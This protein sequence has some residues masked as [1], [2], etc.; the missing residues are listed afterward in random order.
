M[1]K[2]IYSGDNFTIV[3]NPK[4]FVSTPTPRPIRHFT[5]DVSYLTKVAAVSR[6]DQKLPYDT[7][8]G[9]DVKVLGK[10]FLACG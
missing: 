8:P 7:R 1:Q 5:R 2:A 9:G 3:S 10:I 4:V 6:F